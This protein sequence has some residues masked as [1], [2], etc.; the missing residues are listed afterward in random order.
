MASGLGRRAGNLRRGALASA[1]LFLLAVV[2]VGCA[3]I[4]GGGE[5]PPPRT[6][7]G[8]LGQ[9]ASQ[10][11]TAS[12]EGNLPE[13]N[14]VQ[15][16]VGGDSGL[17]YV[18][19]I[20]TRFENTPVGGYVPEEFPLTTA[21]DAPYPPR[22]EAIV[23]KEEGTDGTLTVAVVDNEGRPLASAE[24][25]PGEAEVRLEWSAERNPPPE[26]GPPV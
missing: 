24:A 15:V 2:L 8:T 18:G 12:R 6:P 7:T 26:Q 25:G 22:V 11:T 14:V 9:C 23:R 3:Q 20:C 13:E 19:R 5:T 10:E 16:R 17:Q 1:L 4:V 21:G